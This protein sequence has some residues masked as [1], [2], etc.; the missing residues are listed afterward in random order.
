MA[1]HWMEPRLPT[2]LD[3]LFQAS[4]RTNNYCYMDVAIRVV[5]ILGFVLLMVYTVECL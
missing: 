2:W 3:Y 1:C 5:T 4:V